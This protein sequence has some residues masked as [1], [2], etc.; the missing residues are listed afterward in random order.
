MLFIVKWTPS[1][2]SHMSEQGPT[3]DPSRRCSRC[4]AAVTNSFIR[5]FAIGET[6]HGCLDCLSRSE[7]SSGKAAKR[8]EEDTEGQQTAWR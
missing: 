7:I 6:V 2:G 8:S 3:P 1:N 4:G 5:V